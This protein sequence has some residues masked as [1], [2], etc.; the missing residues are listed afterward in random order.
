MA[1][2]VKEILELW[3]KLRETKKE[4]IPVYELSH[5]NP[6]DYAIKRK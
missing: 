3:F 4:Y 2:Q 1:T 6:W 5:R